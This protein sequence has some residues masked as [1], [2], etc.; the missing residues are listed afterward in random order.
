MIKYSNNIFLKSEFGN[1][2]LLLTGIV[3][4]D[5]N[6]GIRYKKGDENF[7]SIRF[8]IKPIGSEDYF[9]VCKVQ[10]TEKI[11]FILA[12]SDILVT[13]IENMPQYEDLIIEIIYDGNDIK[14]K[15]EVEVI[16]FTKK[17]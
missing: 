7:I 1:T 16:I 3:Y 9:Y 5:F 10:S 17:Y 15:G 12:S 8:K 6:F 2:V 13:K 14:D 4:Y 11:E